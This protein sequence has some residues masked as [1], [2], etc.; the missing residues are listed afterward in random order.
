MS[1][2]PKC[3]GCGKHVRK[4]GYRYCGKCVT[5]IRRQMVES[6]YFWPIPKDED[7]PYSAQEDVNETKHGVDS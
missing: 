6:N 4:E 7:R 5:A 1:K 2:Q 3:H